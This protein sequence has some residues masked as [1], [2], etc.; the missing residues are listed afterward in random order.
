MTHEDNAAVDTPQSSQLDLFAIA[1]GMLKNDK[2]LL[3]PMLF[4]LGIPVLTEVGMDLNDMVPPIAPVLFNRF[5]QIAVVAFIVLRW[6]QRLQKAGQSSLAPLP[7]VGRISVVSLVISIV[8]FL[9]MIAAMGLAQG[10]SFVLVVLLGLGMM[11]TYRMYLFF[12]VA[13][14]LGKPLLEGISKSAS[15][16]RGNGKH[17]MR[18][19]IAPCAYTMLLVGICQMPYPDGRSLG[20]LVAASVAEGTFWILSTYTALALALTLVSDSD[21]RQAGLDHYRSERLT[22]LAKQGG[23]TITQYI[24]PKFGGAMLAVAL[25][26][27]AGNMIR[28]LNQPPAATVVIKN[29][30]VEDYKIQLALEVQDD[31]YDFRGFQPFALSIRT[32]TGGQLVEKLESISRASDKEEPVMLLTKGDGP[33]ADLFVTYSSTKT[34]AS[35]TGLDNMWLWYKS[36]P[37]VAVT[38][39]LLKKNL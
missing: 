26:L 20:W 16:I 34:K 36:K 15:L 10:A 1:A 23:E 38:P 7:V 14:L 3:A 37:L 13:G 21:W 5:I 25:L 33:R 27:W 35:L 2:G 19:L 24:S 4:V 32:A 31:E 22:T 39:E 8:L 11:W 28:Q 29:V 12:A 6:R 9:P 30:S 18:S 17:L